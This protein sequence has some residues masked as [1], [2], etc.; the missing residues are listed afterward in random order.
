MPQ[1]ALSDITE[2]D[3]DRDEHPDGETLTDDDA[4]DR[5]DREDEETFA[6]HAKNK[7]TSS[8]KTEY[9]DTIHTALSPIL[10]TIAAKP[11][12][13]QQAGKITK[14]MVSMDNTMDVN[15]LD[16]KL[17]ELRFEL[18]AA[19]QSPSA[20]TDLKCQILALLNE[21]TAARV[22][23]LV[24]Q[25]DLSSDEAQEL[26]FKDEN[27][28]EAFITMAIEDAKE[29]NEGPFF[30]SGFRNEEQNKKYFMSKWR[31]TATKIIATLKDILKNNTYTYPL[32]HFTKLITNPVLERSWYQ[33]MVP[34]KVSFDLMKVVQIALK[35]EKLNHTE[36]LLKL[37]NDVTSARIDDL[38]QKVDLMSDT[39]VRMNL[40]LDHVSKGTNELAKRNDIFA[41][42][43]VRL[44]T[45]VL[46]LPEY[47]KPQKKKAWYKKILSA[48]A[49]DANA[50]PTLL[51][52]LE[53]RA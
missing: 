28:R 48:D 52:Q 44:Q 15:S 37:Q 21:M 40:L 2:E 51:A 6:E 42:E 39:I 7:R 27:D 34:R 47:T 12:T 18:C 24:K 14:I 5:I 13:R 25:N 4:H 19:M 50:L 16:A 8:I 3:G 23:W 53:S 20:N 17:K 35:A 10:D 38:Q 22:T 32:Y 11:K 26:I 33:H 49:S 43:L 46:H 29:K 31:E 1:R 30:I 36:N 9:L 41:D 45:K